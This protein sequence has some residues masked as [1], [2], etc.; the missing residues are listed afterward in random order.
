MN[1]QELIE[2][3]QHM[4]PEAEVHFAYCYGDYWRTQV[5]ATIDEVSRGFVRHSAYHDMDKVVELDS[6]DEDGES[7]REVV[8]LG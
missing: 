5:S 3:L 2:R 1:V 6:E 4:D 7:V 8:I